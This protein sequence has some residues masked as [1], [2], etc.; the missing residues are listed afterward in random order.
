MTFDSITG[1]GLVM[2]TSAT[3]PTSIDAYSFPW[4]APLVPPFPIRFRDT[5]ILRFATGR[6]RQQSTAY[7]PP[8]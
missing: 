6:T 7:S 4:D 1:D 5:E 3:A 8:R 2:A